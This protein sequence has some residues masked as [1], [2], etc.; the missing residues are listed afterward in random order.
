[1][2]LLLAAGLL[3]LAA[4]GPREVV[5][6][7]PNGQS[8]AVTVSEDGR[9]ATLVLPDRT[10][11][12]PRTEGETGMLFTEQAIYLGIDGD[13]AFVAEGETVSYQDCR[14]ER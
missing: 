14:A 13:E 10:L 3:A 12:L 5:Y 9:S 6:R 1:M 2:R 7:C 8:F 4:C 11:V